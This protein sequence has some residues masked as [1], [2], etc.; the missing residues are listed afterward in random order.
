MNI[1]EQKKNLVDS[2][3][4]QI[5]LFFTKLINST[6]LP[7]IYAKFKLARDSYKGQSPSGTLLAANPLS[8]SYLR[9]AY[10]ESVD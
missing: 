8:A 4:A 6:E 1:T 2:K 9:P 3:S 10:G 7:A 5:H